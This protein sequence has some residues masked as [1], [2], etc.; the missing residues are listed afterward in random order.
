[1]SSLGVFDPRPATAL[2]AARG[3]ISS[4]V[5]IFFYFI[6][7]TQRQFFELKTTVR[8]AVFKFQ[9]KPMNSYFNLFSILFSLSAGN[10]PENTRTEIIDLQSNKI[11][12]E[13][14][15]NVE[16]SIF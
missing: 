12:R 16:L 5:S 6:N 13:M 8:F 11:L 15:N 7:N 2:F 4:V 3:P 9:S 1:M 10:V 14:Y